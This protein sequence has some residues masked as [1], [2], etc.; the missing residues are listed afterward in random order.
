MERFNDP[1]V[2]SVEFDVD[3]LWGCCGVA[4]VY[5]VSF[6]PNNYN[7]AGRIALYE[8]F[9]KHITTAGQPYDL[10]RVKIMMSDSVG[11]TNCIYEFCMEVG[12]WEYGKDTHNPKSGNDVRVFEVNR[13][14]NKRFNF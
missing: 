8:A 1:K 3:K 5:D 14:I 7:R 9:Y 10:N 2:G 4:V 6:R 13:E 11:G 12:G